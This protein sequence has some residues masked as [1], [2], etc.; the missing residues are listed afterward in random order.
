[1][2]NDD[3]KFWKWVAPKLRREGYTERTLAAIEACLDTIEAEHLS[4]HQIEHML[5]SMRAHAL[6]YDLHGRREPRRSGP[7]RRLDTE[8]DRELDR[9]GWSSITATEEGG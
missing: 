8:I 6:P 5:E 1:M 9:L 2:N 4:P 3:N 7:A